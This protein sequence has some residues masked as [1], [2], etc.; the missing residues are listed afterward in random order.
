MSKKSKR[1]KSVA[2]TD[3]SVSN[4]SPNFRKSKNWLVIAIICFLEFGVL[5]A[6]L[7][8]LDEDVGNFNQTG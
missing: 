2:A 7:K 3:L 1:T 4:D 5:G 6:G 8:Y